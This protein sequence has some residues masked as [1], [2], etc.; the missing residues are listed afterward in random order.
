MYFNVILNN[1]IWKTSYLK[2]LDPVVNGRRRTQMPAHVAVPKVPN[3]LQVVMRL[4]QLTC[5]KT[6]N[7]RSRF[8]PNFERIWA[9]KRANNDET[10]NG[11]QTDPKSDR[12]RRSSMQAVNGKRADKHSDHFACLLLAARYIGV[13][14]ACPERRIFFMHALWRG[15]GRRAGIRACVRPSVRPSGAPVLHWLASQRR[16]SLWCLLSH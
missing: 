6:I 10:Q 15:V 12:K 8:G 3:P 16:R 2:K 13:R 5:L 14:G 7:V 4:K 1:P 11:P 9:R